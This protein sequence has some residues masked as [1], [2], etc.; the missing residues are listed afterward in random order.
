MG[1]SPFWS[2]VV[3]WIFGGPLGAIVGY[4]LGSFLNALSKANR[5]ESNADQTARM[6]FMT[7]LLVLVAAT[8]KADGRTSRSEL[9]VV[10][11]FFL[12]QF[13][14]DITQN[15][16]SLLRD[17][18]KQDIQT[19]D[20]CQQIR[21]NMNYSQRMVL[22]HFLY[23]IAHADDEL[24]AK[25]KQLLQRVAAEMGIRPNDAQSIAAMFA[26]RH[27]IR[28]DYQILEIDASATDD[29]V[30]KAYRRMS[31]K[32]HPD[33]VAHLGPDIQKTA[34]EKFQTISAAYSRIKQKRGMG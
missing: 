34:T 12:K 22:L 1:V 24:H 2:G 32:H 13:G 17:L 27:N 20:V 19:S 6:D 7:S 3:G 15:A 14:P 33:K 11:H 16:L 8:M 5:G 25:E 10:R 9:D 28:S 18:L 23:S 29:D 30:R 4:S 31:M 21:L 26:P